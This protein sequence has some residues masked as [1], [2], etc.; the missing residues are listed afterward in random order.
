MFCECEVDVA[1][2]LK[3]A[4]QWDFEVVISAGRH[5]F[6]GASSTKGVVVGRSSVSVEMQFTDEPQISAK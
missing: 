3:Y 5:S 1:T 6:Y 2:A 4:Q